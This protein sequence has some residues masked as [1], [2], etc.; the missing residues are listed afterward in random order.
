MRRSFGS[1]ENSSLSRGRLSQEILALSSHI[2]RV[3]RTGRELDL[4]PTP[5]VGVV[6]GLCTTCPWWSLGRTF[7]RIVTDRIVTE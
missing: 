3:T 7:V 6:S 1:G 5:L 4:N 2:R